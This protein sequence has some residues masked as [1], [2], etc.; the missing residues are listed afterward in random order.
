MEIDKGI[1]LDVTEIDAASNRGI[2]E[3]RSLKESVHLSPT[4]YAYKVFIID[5]AHQLTKEAWN[6]LLK[7]I[8]E[9]PAHAIFILATTEYEK[10]PA[11]IA[12]RAQRFHF[13]KPALPE[14]LKKLSHIVREEHL[15]VS[16][17][18]LELIAASAEGSFRDAESLVDQLTSLSET[19][20]LEIT[21][22]IVGKIGFTRIADLTD[23]ILRRD[24]SAS[25][26]QVHALEAGG[27]NI[28]EATK[29]LI[30]YFRRVLTVA[31]DPRMLE[32]FKQE[33]TDREAVRIQEHS[34]LVK[35]ELHI[36]FLRA[37][38][39][40]WSDMRYSPFAAI[41]LEVAIIEHLE[42]KKSAL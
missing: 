19:V 32:I 20:T 30:H 29:E 39:A 41:P 34:M 28:V 21:E 35:F 42:N 4:S 12:S 1:A 25:L 5:E 16:P 23:A 3:I 24:L 38:I 2:D 36:P 26:E 33:L 8:E 10:V 11:T 18:A 9:P 6:A 14:I 37:L 15:K 40:G 7:T 17:D 31:A 27:G 22:G 13:Q